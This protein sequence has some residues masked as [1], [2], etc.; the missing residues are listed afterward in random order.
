MPTFITEV[1]HIV[2]DVQ[3][4]KLILLFTEKLIHCYL[5]LLWLESTIRF[6]TKITP[7]KNN[8]SKCHIKKTESSITY[9]TSYFQAS[10]HVKCY[11]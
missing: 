4:F 5:S 3:L 6:V 10:F 11:L 8:N 7:I 9:I 2:G 1:I